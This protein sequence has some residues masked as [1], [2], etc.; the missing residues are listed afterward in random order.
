LGEGALVQ[1]VP[2][3]GRFPRLAWDSLCH[4]LLSTAEFRYLR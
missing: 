3:P 2:D 1:G 4:A